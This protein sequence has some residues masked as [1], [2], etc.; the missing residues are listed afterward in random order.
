MESLL[1]CSP[2]R[3]WLAPSSHCVPRT[4]WTA[5]RPMM[6]IR[7]QSGDVRRGRGYK[8]I[9]FNI[10]KLMIV[11]EKV[12]AR[13][14]FHAPPRA[15]VVN[16][17]CC[18]RRQFSLSSLSLTHT[19]MAT[20]ADGRKFHGLSNLATDE[21]TKP[22]L[23]PG[24][25]RSETVIPRRPRTPF[26]CALNLWLGEKLRRTHAGADT[27]SG[28]PLQ[29]FSQFQFFLSKLKVTLV[30]RPSSD[31]VIAGRLVLFAGYVRV[32]PNPPFM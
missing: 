24:G 4:D 12:I 23:S 7:C 15:V 17:F 22:P 6:E 5:S 19:S 3:R 29:A 25:G 14:C 20:M 26:H 9:N 27:Q 10:R 31:R 18:R 21:R 2:L 32:R 13:L 8:G 1:A 11:D 30:R 28:C 16:T